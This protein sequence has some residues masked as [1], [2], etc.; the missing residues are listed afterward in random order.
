MKILNVMPFS[1]VPKDFGGAL[2]EYYI[3]QSLASEHEVTVVTYG[4]EE[5]FDLFTREF[6][7]LVNE[8][9]MVKPPWERK[10]RRLAQFYAVCCS[11]KSYFHNHNCSQCLQKKITELLETKNFDA[12]HCEFS[13]MGN[14]NF[15]NDVLKIMNT[16]NV[17]YNNFRRMWNTTNTAF[18]KRFYRHEY[19]KV[20]HEEIKALKNQDVIF[21]TSEKDREIFR[22]DIP[23]VPNYVVPNGV[24]TEFFTPSDIIDEEPYSLVFTG[25][26]GY[27]PNYDGMLWFLDNIFPK[28]KKQIPNIK[29]YIVGKNPPAELEKRALDDVVVTGFVDDVRPYVWRSSVFIVPLRMGSG[30]RLKVVEALSMKKPV[31]STSIGCEGIEVVDG[32]SILIEDEPK[33]FA[34]AVVQLLQNRNLRSHLTEN[35]YRL[36]KEKYD[37]SVVGNHMLNVY[38]HLSAKQESEIAL[39]DV[40]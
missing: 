32:D 36:V 40:S 14:L 23:D 15:G 18:R 21:S 5:Q 37:W 31:V 38:D 10:F 35:G 28:I 20:Y 27:V 22:K 30:T 2:R 39:A 13:V 4:T 24:D 7:D 16:H 34:E 11:G 26:M 1:P 19:K 17:E 9:H 12:V 33:D 8:I 6:G 25:M 29:V 3:L